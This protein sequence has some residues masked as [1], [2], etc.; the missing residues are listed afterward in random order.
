[1]TSV[2]LSHAGDPVIRV[3][4]TRQQIP[5][6][7]AYLRSLPLPHVLLDRRFEKRFEALTLLNPR[8]PGVTM[9]LR[10]GGHEEN[11]R[12]C[13]ENVN[14]YA[15]CEISN[16]GKKSPDYERRDS[17]DSCLRTND[18]G[19]N[20]ES[21]FEAFA[22]SRQTVVDKF[23]SILRTSV[24]DRLQSRFRRDK[25]PIAV[26][27]SGGVDSLLLAA[28]AA[29]LLPG[30]TM[31]LLN[32]SFDVPGSAPVPDRVT[33]L[34]AVEDLKRLYPTVT[35][36]FVCIDVARDDVVDF[37]RTRLSSL[38]LPL[39]SVLDESLALGLWFAARAEGRVDGV[40]FVSEARI[41]FSGIGPDE[42]LAG[43]ARHRTKWVFLL[44]CACAYE[45]RLN[46]SLLHTFALAPKFAKIHFLRIHIQVPTIDMS[47][48]QCIT[49][50]LLKAA[51][52]DSKF[53]MLFQIPSPRPRCPTVGVGDGN[54]SNRSSQL[55]SRRSHDQRLREGT[56]DSLSV[57]R[58][59]HLSESSACL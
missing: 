58:S 37:K 40:R 54:K 49:L 11:N 43:Y 45:L 35:F 48:C 55:G 47:Q 17:G 46:F 29:E 36:R 38:L 21:I 4:T 6:L 19:V 27:F 51:F 23:L 33:G 26:L 12:E 3:H 31:D 20:I 2:H 10:H 39:D 59:H 25:C 13:L 14:V 52:V 53:S 41:L 42:M 1:M 28:L 8:L 44:R 5:A 34:A 18:I 15:D 32:V 30:K 57:R 56:A 9:T 22:R 24:N 7:D 16:L 50:L